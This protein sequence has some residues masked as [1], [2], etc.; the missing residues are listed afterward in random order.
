MAHEFKLLLQCMQ[1]ILESC[2]MQVYESLSNSHL[3]TW[4]KS[5]ISRGLS[6]RLILP[7]KLSQHLHLNTS[8]NTDR[9][10]DLKTLFLGLY[11]SKVCLCACI[12]ARGRESFLWT[13]A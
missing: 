7:Y 3:K 2:S 8:L 9:K 6:L 12:L 1:N 5:N 11:L 4:C 10:S 13:E